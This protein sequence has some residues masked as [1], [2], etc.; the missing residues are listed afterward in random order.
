VPTGPSGDGKLDSTLANEG[1]EAMESGMFY[2]YAAS[3]K[4]YTTLRRISD[5]TIRKAPI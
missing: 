4:V 3:N 2:G 1:V 5:V